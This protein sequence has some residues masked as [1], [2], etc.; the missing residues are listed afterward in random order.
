MKFVFL[1]CRFSHPYHAHTRTRPVPVNFIPVP[2]YG[3]GHPTRGLQYSSQVHIQKKQDCEIYPKLN[4]DEKSS[5]EVIQ[6]Y[7]ETTNYHIRDVLKG[8][9]AN[10]ELS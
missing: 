7:V 1:N 4:S 2:R 3:Y 10:A 9:K 5:Y 8:I 6:Y